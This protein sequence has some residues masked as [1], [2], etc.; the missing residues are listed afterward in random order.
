MSLKDLTHA[1]HKAAET[2]PF[3]KV[4]FSG[5]IDPK[6][7]ATF[8]KNQHP[9]YEILEVCAMPHGLM[10]EYPAIRRA[11]A[12]L[13]DFTELWGQDNP[14]FPKMCPVVDEYIKYIL[15][16]KD[17]PKKLLAHLYVRHFGDLS[18]GQMIAKR[19]PGSG[20]MY[21]FGD[22]PETIKT[23]LRAKLDDSL[24]EEAI[25]CFDFAGKLFEQMMDIAKDYE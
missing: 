7:Y 20:K 13:Q 10:S 22:D 6:L 11:P 5:K 8:L 16:I 23:I 21:Q 12:I 3:V 25:V 9:C 15:N 17:D 1:A 4:L 14:T 18:G 24:A 19:V 2:K